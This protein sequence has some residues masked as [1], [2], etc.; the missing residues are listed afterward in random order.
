MGEGSEII[1]VSAQPQT[2][3]IGVVLAT[4]L[5]TGNMVGT[6]I[7]LLPAT[8]ASVGSVSLLGWLAVTAGAMML[9]GVF[10]M[11]STLRPDLS[12][13]GYVSAAFGQYAGFQASI[14]YWTSCW[15]GN[16][17]IA[18]GVTGY[19]AYFVPM[20]A[21]SWPG[22]CCTC[23]VI[24]GLTAANLL[25]PRLVGRLGGMT[26][27]LGLVPVLGV[28]SLGWF[29]FRPAIFAASWNVTGHS[30]MQ[31][32]AASL[33]LIFWAFLG[34][35]TGTVMAR[36]VR[37]PSRNIPLATLG[38]V[39]LTGL[40]SIAA[41]TAIQGVL[42][43]STLARSPAPF[44]DAVQRM[45]GAAA[46]GAVALCALLKASGTLGGWVLVTAE[47]TCSAAAGGLFP[48]WFGAVDQRGVPRR[49]LL[50]MCMVMCIFCV[51]TVSPTVAR[52]FQVVIDVTSVLSLLVYVWC[53]LA[54]IR[55]APARPGVWL[56]APVSLC[57][58]LYVV[59]KSD[60]S[61]LLWAL[62]LVAATVPL[63]WLGPRRACGAQR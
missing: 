46:G 54:L 34:L 28:A 10:A 8:L 60:F 27:V 40:I 16:I 7:F 39:A 1:Q 6:G 17:A 42:P 30:G 50:C 35:E 37:N 18:V 36:L 29:W 19:A 11:L 59:A 5:I 38:G 26:L 31:A 12:L 15:A 20:L 51:L 44:G 43:A 25:G 2:A 49:A 61:L 14:L 9:A 4:L 24:I 52:Q 23:A 22:C 3:R 21:R 53:C 41:C 47:T 55:M 13:T 63:Y 57:F 58:C 32:V 56:L 45:V 33:V 62:A 48:A